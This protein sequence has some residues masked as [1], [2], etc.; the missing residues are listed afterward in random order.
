MSNKIFE[1]V[2]LLIS[3]IIFCKIIFSISQSASRTKLLE[4]KVDLLVKHA[5]IDPYA[6]IPEEVV[7]MARSGK[8]IEAIT[9]YRKLSTVG[10]VEAKDL[11]EEIAKDV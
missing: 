3:A 2:I 4:R 1:A 10:L 11:V 8:K 5:G 6:D 7:R 9:L